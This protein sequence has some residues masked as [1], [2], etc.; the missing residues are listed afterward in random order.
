MTPKLLVKHSTFIAT[1]SLTTTQLTFP[2]LSFEAK[3]AV[4]QVHDTQVTGEALHLHRDSLA[5]HH[6]AD[7]SF[8]FF[9][10][11]VCCSTSSWHPT[12]GEALHLH[13]D[14]LADHHTADLSFFFFWSQV[15]CSTSSW[16]PSYW[17]STPPSSRLTRWPPL[18]WPFRLAPQTGICS[19]GFLLYQQVT[20]LAI[21]M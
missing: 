11:P 12:T 14:S 15:C 7:L 5:D 6:T 4:L 19:W 8:S 1:H 16:H 3:S 20:N 18:S 21:L 17:W 9:W 13:G 2:F 10:S